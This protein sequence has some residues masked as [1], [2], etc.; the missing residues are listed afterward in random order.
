MEVNTAHMNVHF[1]SQV[2]E[3][4]IDEP[5]R[6]AVLALLSTVKDPEMPAV[7]LLELGMVYKLEVGRGHVHVELIPTFIGCPALEIMR[8]NVEKAMQEIDHIS[9][10]EVKFV[11]DVPWSSDRITPEGREKLKKSGI[12]PALPEISVKVAPS[13][14][15]CAST[16]TK[17]ENLFGPTACRSIFYCNQ[18]QQPFEGMKHV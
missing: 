16:N 6:A 10:V 4:Q 2:G 1:A 13:C 14:P 18:C 8:R 17:V 5:I 7:S 12:A 9:S 15:Y 11:L 3:C